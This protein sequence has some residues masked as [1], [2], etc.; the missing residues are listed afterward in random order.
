MTDFGPRNDP[1]PP[2]GHPLWFK[3]SV[4]YTGS[5]SGPEVVRNATIGDIFPAPPLRPLSTGPWNSGPCTTFPEMPP[6]HANIP[7]S[8]SLCILRPPLDLFC[9]HIPMGVENLDRSAH[10]VGTGS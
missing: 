6:I 2:F 4:I 1:P 9:E 10:C 5:E 8:G 7:D 3:K